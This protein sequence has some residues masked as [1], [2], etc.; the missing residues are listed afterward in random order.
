M[1]MEAFAKGLEIE[2][3]NQRIANQ[4]HRENYPHLYD[5]SLLIKIDHTKSTDEILRDAIKQV[6]S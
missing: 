5:K 2:R 6:C 1:D 3:E 4:I